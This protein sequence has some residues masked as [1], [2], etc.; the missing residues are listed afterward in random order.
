MHAEPPFGGLHLSEL[1]FVEHDVTPLALVRQQVTNPGLPHVDLAAHFTT[2]PW[3][4]LFA[5]V[6]LA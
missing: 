5:S 6:A 3:Q 2:T 1:D 4:L